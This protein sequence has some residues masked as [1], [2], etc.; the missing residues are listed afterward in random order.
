M[1]RISPM[2]M[3]ATIIPAHSQKAIAM[4][5]SATS[6]PSAVSYQ[7]NGNGCFFPNPNAPNTENSTA[8]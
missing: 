6:A 7:R 2:G 1:T 4:S 5:L 3:R 8:L